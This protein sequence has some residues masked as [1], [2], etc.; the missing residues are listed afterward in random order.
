MTTA[1]QYGVTNAD[2]IAGQL[3]RISRQLEIADG[4]ELTADEK[5]F[6]DI[7]GGNDLSGCAESIKDGARIISECANRMAKNEAPG[8]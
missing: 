5:C 3:K 2:I 6:D 4:A 7:F 8:E 1:N